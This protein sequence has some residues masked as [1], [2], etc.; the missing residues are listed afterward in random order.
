MAFGE[1]F[2][3]GHSEQASSILHAWVANHRAGFVSF[4]LLM[5]V[6]IK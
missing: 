5:E 4:C 1:I 3:A 6:F 2:L